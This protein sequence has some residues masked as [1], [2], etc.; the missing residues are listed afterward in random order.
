M[1]MNHPRSELV[2]L[3]KT[4]CFSAWGIVNLFEAAQ[5]CLSSF[6]VEEKARLTLL[7]CHA[8]NEG[9]IANVFPHEKD[10]TC[11]RFPEKPSRP[12][13]AYV[14]EKQKGELEG[15]KSNPRLC[16]PLL[17]DALRSK[18]KN[19][20]KKNAIEYT[21]HGIA[22]AES[23][24]IDLF[25]DL[26]GRFHRDTSLLPKE[27]FDVMVYI[28]QQES[29]HFTSWRNRLLEMGFTFGSFPFQDGLWQSA[30]DTSGT[31]CAWWFIYFD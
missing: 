18:V 29:H 30:S 15:L 19:L 23:Y 31:H 28:V 17:S 13:S 6:N 26:I 24:A 9:I 22:N 4:R 21:V 8:W 12:L 25:W 7:Y 3:R 1:E 2:T 27:F 16:T 11:I 10:L 14:D 5:L 20:M